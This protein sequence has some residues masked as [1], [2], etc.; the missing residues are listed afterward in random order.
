M[1]LAPESGIVTVEEN[2]T[3]HGTKNVSILVLALYNSFL[4]Y[5]LKPVTMFALPELQDLVKMSGCSLIVW[6]KE[7]VII[8]N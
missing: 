7:Q 6:L 5:V 2:T 4:F 8:C 3:S 1:T